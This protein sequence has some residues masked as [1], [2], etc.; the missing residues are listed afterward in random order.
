LAKNAHAN[1]IRYKPSQ[2]HFAWIR[3]KSKLIRRILKTQSLLV[4]KLPWQTLRKPKGE[5]VKQL[6]E[7]SIADI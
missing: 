3:V 5:Y 2:T 1:S 7:K 6:G 4:A